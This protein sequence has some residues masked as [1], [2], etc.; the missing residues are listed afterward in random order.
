MY[1]AKFGLYPDSKNES[2]KS[3]VFTIRRIHLERV[4]RV[5]G[6]ERRLGT[7]RPVRRLEQYSRRN[8]VEPGPRLQGFG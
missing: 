2:L 7:R 4:C 1:D 8:P 6:R 5:R 3:S